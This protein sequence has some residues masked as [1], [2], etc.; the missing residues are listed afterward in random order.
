MSNLI[1]WIKVYKHELQCEWIFLRTDLSA[2]FPANSLHKSVSFSTMA[3]ASSSSSAWK[4]A[5]VRERVQER[6]YECE[7][8]CVCVSESACE[9]AYECVCLYTN[10]YPQIYQLSV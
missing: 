10:E 7:Q 9:C 1:I 3:R 6:V 4:C 2:N 8:V 5:F